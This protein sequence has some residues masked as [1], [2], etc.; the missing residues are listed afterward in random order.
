MAQVTI[1]DPVVQRSSASSPPAPLAH[2][3][4]TYTGAGRVESS[5]LNSRLSASAL[6]SSARTGSVRPETS[7]SVSCRGRCE[8]RSSRPRGRGP[9]PSWEG[10]GQLTILERDVQE[11]SNTGS[12]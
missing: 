5:R 10:L 9:G 4:T 11:R 12:N 1:I 3:P 7:Q 6:E 8:R 2:D